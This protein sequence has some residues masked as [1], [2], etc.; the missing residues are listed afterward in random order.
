MYFT[1]CSGAVGCE[2]EGAALKYVLARTVCGMMLSGSFTC[3]NAAIFESVDFKTGVVTLSNVQ[4]GG[5]SVA[6]DRL[7]VQTAPVSKHP[8]SLVD[9][10]KAPTILAAKF[11]Q[12]QMDDDRQRILLS[13]LTKANAAMQAAVAANAPVDVVMRHKGDTA[14]IEREISRL[15]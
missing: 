1:S 12:R 7:R 8:S 15:R 6:S 11:Q 14:A 5:S 2:I 4:R 3:V 9:S 13:E 10:T